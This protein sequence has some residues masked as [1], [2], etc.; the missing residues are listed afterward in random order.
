MVI[1]LET[2]VT[3][4]ACI[5]LNVS[6]EQLW[7]IACC[8]TSLAMLIV[9]YSALLSV[10]QSSDGHTVISPQPVATMGHSS[11][12]PISFIASPLVSD[13]KS[14][15]EHWHSRPIA[16]QGH[17]SDGHSVI[18][19][20]AVATKSH[21]SDLPIS[22]TSLA[23]SGTNLHKYLLISN[24]LRRWIPWI[25]QND[26]RCFCGISLLHFYALN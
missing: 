1:F 16:T 13:P 17:S 9:S 7:S 22:P 6:F 10:T 18:S 2:T 5:L 3:R 15:W 24:V 23:E 4:P 26:S 20:W 8:P 14:Q 11:D 19:P 12:L 25:H 21:N